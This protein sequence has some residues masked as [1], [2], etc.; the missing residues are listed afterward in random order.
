MHCSLSSEEH[1]VERSDPP[2]LFGQ[3]LG[4]PVEKALDWSLSLG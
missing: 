1:D 2:F 4:V 3:V